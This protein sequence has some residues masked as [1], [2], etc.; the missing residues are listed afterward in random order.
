MAAL[1]GLLSD[2][3]FDPETTA[4]MAL[5]FDKACLTI[6][7]TQQVDVIKEIIAKRI[8]ALARAGETNADSL[9]AGA[10]QTLGLDRPSPNLASSERGI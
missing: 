7:G 8:I 6:A 4:A 1:V 5:A 10:L 3:A 2:S 9:S